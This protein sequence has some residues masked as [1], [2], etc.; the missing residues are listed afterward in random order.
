M[1][2]KKHL[3]S[4]KY[5]R[6]EDHVDLSCDHDGCECFTSW[7]G[8][9]PSN[10]GFRFDVLERD[11]EMG[12]KNFIEEYRRMYPALGFSHFRPQEAHEMTYFQSRLFKRK[13]YPP[14]RT[15]DSLCFHSKIGS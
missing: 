2:D 6:Y 12:R 15:S 8:N 13:Q 3:F 11:G 4:Q 14:N 10:N 7:L 5:F 1:M 9:H